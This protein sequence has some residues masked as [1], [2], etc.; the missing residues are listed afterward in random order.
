MTRAG[1]CAVAV[2][3]VAAAAG[4]AQAHK[5]SDAHLQLAVDGDVVRGRLDVAVRD[6]DAALALDRDGDGRITW[7]ELAIA[8]D[9]IDGY[10][11]DHLDVTDGPARC[12]A[13]RS[14]RRSPARTP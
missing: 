6:L 3:V 1:R 9:R 7:G 11:R 2:A 14:S 8:A 4:S 10:V 5:P 13:A 12:P